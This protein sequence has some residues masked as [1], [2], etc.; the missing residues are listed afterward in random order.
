MAL[1]LSLH[2]GDRVAIGDDVVIELTAFRSGEH[3]RIAFTA[4]Q[5]VLIQREKVARDSTP[6]DRVARIVGSTR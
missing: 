6:F 1:V 5:D 4:P 3:V 2:I